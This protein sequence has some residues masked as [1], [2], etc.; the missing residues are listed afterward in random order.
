MQRKRS[1]LGNYQQVQF[2]GKSHE[3]MIPAPLP[4]NPPMEWDERL[5]CEY[6]EAAFQIGALDALFNSLPAK[7]E[8]AR[9][10]RWN[11]DDALHPNLSRLS[12]GLKRGV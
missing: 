7:H 2:R 11:E 1:L 5:L 8:L 12:K 3:A 6:E 10:R 4:P 9:Y